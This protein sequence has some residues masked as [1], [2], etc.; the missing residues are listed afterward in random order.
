MRKST[1]SLTAPWNATRNQDDNE[2]RLAT[3]HE[4]TSMSEQVEIKVNEAIEVGDLVRVIVAAPHLGEMPVDGA[5][6]RVMPPWSKK[7]TRFLN[8]FFT[9]RTWATGDYEASYA[10][11]P[12]EVELVD[13]EDPA[14]NVTPLPPET[15][16]QEIERLENKAAYWQERHELSEADYHDRV[17][18]LAAAEAMIAEL[19]SISTRLHSTVAAIQMLTV[20][21]PGEVLEDTISKIRRMANDGLREYSDAERKLAKAA[22]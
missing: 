2:R 15:A 22:K 5:I 3:A 20:T 19:E 18:K 21:Y 7:H 16:Q 4:D 14:L 11:L 6:G 8:V 13:I 10:L 12:N 17:K 1:H 9:H